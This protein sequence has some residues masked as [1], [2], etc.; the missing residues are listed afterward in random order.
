VGPDD[1]LVGFPLVDDAG[2]GRPG[3]DPPLGGPLVP[4]LLAWAPMAIGHHR[5]TWL[6]WSVDLWAPAVVKIVRPGWSRQWTHAL[7]R[8]V[9]ALG[10]I[11][12]PAVPRL[13]EDGRRNTVPHIAVEYLD[14]PCLDECVTSGGPLSAGDT[15]RVGVQVLGALRA[16]HATGSAH[17]DISPGNVLLVD[18]RPRLIDLGSSRPLGFQLRPGEALGTDGFLAPE[19]DGAPGGPVTAAMDVYSL[20]ATLLAVLDR[21]SD[22][23]DQVEDR[24]SALTD[25]DPD[26]RPSTDLAI[27]SLIRCAGTGASRPWPRWADRYLPRPP[28]RRRRTAPR[29]SSVASS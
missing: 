8:E 6:C 3:W 27:S 2:D 22:G 24:L 13:L 7:D 1:A 20:G 9:R 12:H 25:P 16:V 19:L 15:A 21:A 29:L 26:R 11:A 17:L 18:R 10:N 4:G 5:E 23:A 28:R 14:G